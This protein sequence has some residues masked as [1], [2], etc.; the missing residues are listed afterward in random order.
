MVQ[1]PVGD[2]VGGGNPQWTV[3][4]W[5]QLAVLCKQSVYCLISHP[6]S[7]WKPLHGSLIP[8]AITQA[9]ERPELAAVVVY[10]HLVPSSPQGR[11]L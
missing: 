6:F 3:Q 1:M 8:E 10:I 11:Q 5:R 9:A 2:T 4:P 7:G